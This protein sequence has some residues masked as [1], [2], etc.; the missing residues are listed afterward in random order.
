M[1]TPQTRN[2]PHDTEVYRVRRNDRA[3]TES[4]EW[5]LGSERVRLLSLCK[6]GSSGDGRGDGL[7]I[8]P[9]GTPPE[10]SL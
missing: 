7:R 1:G 2:L 4:C 10:V 3:Q 8:R 9:C 6:T 5:M